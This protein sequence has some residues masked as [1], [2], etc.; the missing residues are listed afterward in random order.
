MSSDSGDGR[1]LA[2][3]AAATLAFPVGGTLLAAATHWV[4]PALARAT[5]WEPWI[6]WHLTT[7]SV[8]AGL[9]VCAI[10]W[11]KDLPPRA[12][13][14]AERLRFLKMERKHIGPLLMAAVFVA[15][16]T[17]LSQW[18]VRE[19]FEARP[20]AVPLVEPLSGPRIALLA[21]WIPLWAVIVGGEEALWRGVVLRLQARAWPRVAWLINGAGWLLFHWVFGWQTL[22][23]LWPLCLAL[24]LLV[25]RTGNSSVGLVLH[26]AFNGAGFLAV[27]LGWIAPP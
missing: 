23:V 16:A 11:A 26:A 18:V 17:A 6:A 1:G 22:A 15:V 25:Q 12:R 4:V 10:H 3:A 19:M 21:L 8:V 27:A 9:L 13:S 5:T 2:R 20:T 24:P 14:W 7:A